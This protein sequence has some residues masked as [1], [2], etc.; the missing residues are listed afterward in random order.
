MSLRDRFA[1]AVVHVQAVVLA[2][3]EL[4]FLP[5]RLDGTLLPEFHDWPFPVVILLAAGTTPFLVTMAARYATTTLG[6]LSPLLV[7]LGTLIVLG[8]FGPGGDVLLLGDLR[9]LLLFGA[10]AL[11]AAIS[12]GAFMGRQVRER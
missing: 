3:L 2:T 8:L 9:T 1:L 7:W 12:V 10:G 6:A 5:L 4:F 11:P